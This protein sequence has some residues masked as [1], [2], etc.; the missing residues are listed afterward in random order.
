MLATLA[1]LS[2][3]SLVVLDAAIANIALPTLSQSLAV[4]PAAAIRVVTAYQLGLVVSLLPVAALGESVGLRRVFVAGVTLFTFASILCALSPTLDWLVAARFVQGVGG[5][6]IMAL[7]VALLRF[8]VP[9]NQFGL[10]IGW[11]AMTVALASASGP[12]VGAAILTFAPWPWL[13]ALNLPMGALAIYASQALPR[14]PGTQRA[15]DLFSVVLSVCAFALL[16]IGAETLIPAPM[17]AGAMLLGAALI[18]YALTQRERKRVAPLVPFDLL[19]NT[20]F[21][22]SVVASILLFIG[23]AAALIALPF[24]LQRNFGLTPLTT[25]LYMLPWP[26][27]VALAGPFVGKLANTASTSLLCWVGGLILC[28]GLVGAALSPLQAAPLLFPVSMIGC[29]VGFSLFNIANNRNMF[30][31]TSAERSGAT[32]G[33]QSA[34]RL[35]GQTFGA[36][37][38]SALFASTAGAPR[39]GLWFGALLAFSAALVSLQRAKR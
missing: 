6:G 39:L 21:R 18:A 19:G 5:A 24:Y 33:M 27:T 11:N 34:A 13:F 23:Q 12:T 17:L 1:V 37:S 36:V 16:I 10:A 25:G 15:I 22:L 14:V 2:A 30:L 4:T 28:V 35:F 29:G 3:M 8:V 38:M 7:G 31:S 9:Q 20:S 26:L 32:G